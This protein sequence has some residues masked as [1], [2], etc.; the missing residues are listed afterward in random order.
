MSLVTL[1]HPIDEVFA[2]ISDHTHDPAWK[3]TV[4]EARKVSEGP[5]GLGTLFEVTS[6]TGGRRFTTLI[7]VIE[8]DP[9]CLYAYRSHAQPF[10]FEARLEFAPT[11]TGT[12]IS[13]SVRF[14]AR[15]P[16]NWFAPIL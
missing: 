5:I 15:A 2:Y 6:A 12:A 9:P 8:Y 4:V 7:E 10:P 16:Y 3:P 11:S 14:E 1:H 13:G